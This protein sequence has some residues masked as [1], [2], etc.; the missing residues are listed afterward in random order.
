MIRG[1]RLPV[2]SSAVS[3]QT[4]ER[5]EDARELRPAALEQGRDRRRPRRL[6]LRRMDQPNRGGD[7]KAERAGED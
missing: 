1:S 7:P 2:S 4:Q 3:A 5:G 6:A